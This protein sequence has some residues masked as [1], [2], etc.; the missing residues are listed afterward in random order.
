[1]STEVKLTPRGDNSTADRAA[2][3]RPAQS[4]VSP[5]HVTTGIVD[6]FNQ[7]RWVRMTGSVDTC[8]S[9]SA[10]GHRHSN[11]RLTA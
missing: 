9:S 7:P 10:T 2:A 1:M 6:G 4:T 5:V 8:D 3:E 11:G